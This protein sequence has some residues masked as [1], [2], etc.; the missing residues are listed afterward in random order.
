[1]SSSQCGEKPMEGFKKR[2]ALTIE[3]KRGRKGHCE[4]RLQLCDSAVRAQIWVRRWILWETCRFRIECGISGL[5]V[6]FRASQLGVIFTPQGIFENVCG[7]F[8]LSLFIHCSLRCSLCTCYPHTEARN[9][10]KLLQDGP[11]P[12]PNKNYLAQNVSGDKAEKP[13]IRC[14]WRG[15]R[16]NL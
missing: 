13:W 7:P 4:G 16:G 9:A 15:I 14:F 12:S 6:R 10:A 1:M 11:F 2:N 3:Q 5:A 8:R